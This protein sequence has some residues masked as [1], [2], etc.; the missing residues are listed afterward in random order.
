[1]FLKLLGTADALIPAG[2][3]G[4][5]LLA[6]TLFPLK[7]DPHEEKVKRV[8]LLKLAK[9]A[10]GADELEALKETVEKF[11]DMDGIKATFHPSD[12]ALAQH[13]QEYKR[14]TH[15]LLVM[16]SSRAALTDLMSSDEHKVTFAK[17]LLAAGNSQKDMIVHDSPMSV[18]RC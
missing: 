12:P 6:P 5:S 15:C 9:V 14:H 1:M 4:F 11:N 16:A 3:V 2:V 7:D 13:E 10:P 8:C 17:Q 18:V